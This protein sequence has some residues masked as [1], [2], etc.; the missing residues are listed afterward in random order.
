MHSAC[1]DNGDAQLAPAVAGRAHPRAHA[2]G[3][4]IGIFP[5]ERPAI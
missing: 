5:G 4:G 1:A 3:I 2:I